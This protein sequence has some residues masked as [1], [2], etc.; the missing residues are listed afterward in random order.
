MT[1]AWLLVWDLVFRVCEEAV[2]ALPGG[3]GY[4]LERRSGSSLK[5][6]PTL[7]LPLP[8]SAPQAA[9]AAAGKDVTRTPTGSSTSS[10]GR[11]AR[12]WAW[13]RVQLELGVV[14]RRQRFIDGRDV[15]YVTLSEAI[16][17]I[18]VRYFLAF[19]LRD[20]AGGG[21]PGGAGGC[22][23]VPFEA[24]L[25]HLR[26]KHLTRMYQALLQHQQQEEARQW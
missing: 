19:A 7:L 15:L 23:A 13:Q 5:L 26:L 20:Q 2:C 4:I 12:P 14:R 8:S 25:P 9:S 18:D 10:K 16:S 24:L 6:A 21:G 11:A 17:S 22:L 3:V 1:A